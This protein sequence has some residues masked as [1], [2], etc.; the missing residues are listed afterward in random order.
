MRKKTTITITDEA[1]SLIPRR[2]K[3]FLRLFFSRIGLMALLILLQLALA[4]SVYAWFSEYFKWFALTQGVFSLAMILYLFNCS[5]DASAKLTWMFLIS[6]F[7]VPGTIFL[8]FTT[9]NIGNR[10]L[11][12]RVEDLIRETQGS[13]QQNEE[14]FSRAELVDSG[15]DD[16]CRYLNRSG[17]FPIYA[18]TDVRYFPLGERKYEAMLEELRKAESFIFMEYFIIDEGEMWGHILKILADKVKQG[19]DVR[20]MYDGM[21]EMFTLSAD[22]PEKMKTLGIRCKPFSPIMPFVSTHYNYRDHRKIL[23]IDGKV[24]FNGGVNLAD[25]YINRKVRFGHWKDTA[26]MLRGEAVKSFTLLFLQMWN[27]DEKIPDWKEIHVTAEPQTV[28]GYVMPYGD[29]PLDADK[30]GESVYMDIL[31]RAKSYVHIMTP[32][33]ILDNEL[34][35]AL[36][37]AA[38]R[39]IDVRIILPGIPDKK[40]AWALAK[41]HY[42]SLLSAGVKLFEYTPGFVHAKVVVS[43]DEKAVVGTINMDYRS[44]Y[45]HYECA[46]YLYRTACIAEIEQDYQQTESCCTQVTEETT[47][48]EKAYLQALGAVMKLVAPLM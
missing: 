25:E 33:L 13:L 43:D 26:V 28:A 15:T 36:K 39:G 41:S 17:C 20:V 24:A 8:W 38:E 22:Y 48:K 19:V 1:I 34:E 14:V 6:L 42:R 30:V 7:P 46:T 2:K 11:R 5:M 32:Y 35:T 47:R 9:S 3:G 10:T 45:H 21:C 29:C 4:V 44:L 37:Y 23:V 16:L 27:I 40:T 18:D 12:K 31:Y